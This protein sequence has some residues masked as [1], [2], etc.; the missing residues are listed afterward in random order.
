M[1]KIFHALFI[2][3]FICVSAPITGM[4]R[5][6]NI[7]NTQE[8]PIQ[9]PL[10]PL[11]LPTEIIAYIA[12]Y[13][14]PT[15]KNILMKVSKDFNTCLQDKELMVQKNPFT[16]F[17]HDKLKNIFAHTQSGQAPILSIWLK[18]LDNAEGINQHNDEGFAPLHIASNN[19]D[20]AI[21]KMLIKHGAHVNEVA[22]DERTALHIAAQNGDA[23]ITKL[24]IKAQA[25]VSYEDDN[26]EIPL[27]IAS[28]NN[29]IDIVKLLLPAAVNI[30]LDFNS[31]LLYA[32]ENNFTQIVQL[33]LDAGADSNIVNDQDGETPLCIASKNGYFEIVKLLLCAGAKD[34]PENFALYKATQKG[35]TNIVKLL[36]CTGANLDTGYLCLHKATAKGHAEIAQLLINAGANLNELFDIGCWTP[37]LEAALAGQINM[38]KLLLSNGAN[39]NLRTLD[40]L[41]LLHVAAQ[42]GHIEIVKFLIDSGVELNQEDDDWKTPLDLAEE[43]GHTEVARLLELAIES[44]KNMSKE[45][46]E[47]MKNLRYFI[48]TLPNNNKK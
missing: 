27:D 37:L 5:K 47:L 11:W 38:I 17:L 8:N 45:E 18:S 39:H 23:D 15:E 28:E 35:H 26:G 41:T 13:C 31:A 9:E 4:K 30:G 36:L 43:N 48:E 22:N 32:I 21:V 34:T 7:T 12:S 20:K 14:E 24:L 25:D 1:K 3:S 42:E 6:V 46:K 29:H 40:G 19:K 10:E 33:L 2:L 44:L 16:I